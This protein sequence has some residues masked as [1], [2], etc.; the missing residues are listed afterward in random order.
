MLFLCDNVRALGGVAP[1][2][3][4]CSAPTLK[5]L[6]NL[7]LIS[8]LL[9]CVNADFSLCW[10]SSDLCVFIDAS[11]RKISFRYITCSLWFY[12]W[13]VS[14]LESKFICFK[15]ASKLPF[16]KIYALRILQLSDFCI[17]FLRTAFYRLS[18]SALMRRKIITKSHLVTR[19][20]SRS[21]GPYV[22]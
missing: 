8:F 21:P 1:K 22:L 5:E 17:F 6:F 11:G 20:L 12:S 19:T 4:I 2:Q 10:E 3:L 9:C 13:V 15:I 18:R 14:A 16:H 7:I